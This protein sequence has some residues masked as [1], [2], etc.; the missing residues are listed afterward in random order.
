MFESVVAFSHSADS[1][2]LFSASLCS[3]LLGRLGHRGLFANHGVSSRQQLVRA[4]PLS[5]REHRRGLGLLLCTLRGVVSTV[6]RGPTPFGVF[7]LAFVALLILS[8]VYHLWQTFH[9]A[10]SGGRLPYEE[11]R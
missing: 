8:H 10:G 2:V 5:I 4:G 6:P 3:S 1:W 9:S 7:Q 11:R